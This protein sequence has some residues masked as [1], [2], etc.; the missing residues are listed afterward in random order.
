MTEI[1]K[2]QDRAAQKEDE[3]TIARL[4]K[5]DQARKEDATQQEPDKLQATEG[6]SGTDTSRNRNTADRDR[7]EGGTRDAEEQSISSPLE[8]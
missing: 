4:R 6:H 8:Q 7:S 1:E 2:F 5:E 3:A